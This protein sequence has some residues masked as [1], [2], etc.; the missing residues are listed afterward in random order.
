MSQAQR[1]L[2]ASREEAD[3]TLVLRALRRHGPLPLT[4]LYD[5]PPLDGWSSERL[6]GAVVAAWSQNLISIDPGDLLIA[7]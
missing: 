3:A 2:T 4:E 5:E 1:D 6:Q 7:L